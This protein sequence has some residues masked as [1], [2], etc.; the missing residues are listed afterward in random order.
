[1]TLKRPGVLFSANSFIRLGS[2]SAQHHCF[3]NDFARISEIFPSAGQKN[4]LKLTEKAN[5]Y[6]TYLNKYRNNFVYLN[7]LDI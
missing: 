5:V 3:H 7:Y 6:I 1:M 2:Y 4:F